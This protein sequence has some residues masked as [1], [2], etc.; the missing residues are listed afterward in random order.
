MYIFKF[1]GTY[2]MPFRKFAPI[3]SACKSIHTFSNAHI[4]DSTNYKTFFL[5]KLEIFIINLL[6]CLDKKGSFSLFVS[7]PKIVGIIA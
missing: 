6:S 3:C 1:L 5:S 2:Q 4:F 7:V